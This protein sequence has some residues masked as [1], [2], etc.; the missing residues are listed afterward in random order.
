MDLDLKKEACEIEKQTLDLA[1]IATYIS[2][3]PD[4][5]R[6]IKYVNS[7]LSM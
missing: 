2:H 3:K 4:T 1:D 6:V 7:A 5:D